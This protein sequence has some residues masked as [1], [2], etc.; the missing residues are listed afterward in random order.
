MVWACESLD[1]SM[2]NGKGKTW[3]IVKWYRQQPEMV[4][5][6]GSGGLTALWGEESGCDA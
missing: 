1:H 6:L 4:V 2:E 3:Q 5:G